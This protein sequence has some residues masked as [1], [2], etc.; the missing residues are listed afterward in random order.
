MFKLFINVSKWT[1]EY[2]KLF[3]IEIISKKQEMA[4]LEYSRH[5][6]GMKY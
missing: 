2:L 1:N 3:F 6:V 5:R 4:N